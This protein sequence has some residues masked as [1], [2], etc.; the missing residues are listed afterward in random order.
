MVYE[1]AFPSPV[2]ITVA[3]D[4]GLLCSWK[5]NTGARTHS[6]MS[7]QDSESEDDCDGDTGSVPPPPIRLIFGGHD[8]TYA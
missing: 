5:S 6:R 1:S 3:G 4:D 2:S 8:G 7:Q